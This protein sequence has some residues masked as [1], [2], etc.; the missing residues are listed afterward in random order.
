MISSLFINDTVT[1]CCGRREFIEHY[2]ANMS[3]HEG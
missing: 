2:T 1:R 3:V